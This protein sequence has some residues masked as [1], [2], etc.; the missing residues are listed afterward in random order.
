MLRSRKSI[1]LA[2]L[3]LLFFKKILTATIAPLLTTAHKTSKILES[4]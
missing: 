4:K 1:I 3:S 2:A